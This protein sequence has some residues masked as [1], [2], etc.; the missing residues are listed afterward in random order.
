MMPLATGWGRWSRSH[1]RGSDGAAMRYFAGST[2]TG[3][4]QRHVAATS[5]DAGVAGFRSAVH[6]TPLTPPPGLGTEGDPQA[7]RKRDE[8]ERQTKSRQRSF[9]PHAFEEAETG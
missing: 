8:W 3:V 5:L 2:A 4:G 9:G 1:E 7:A 6:P